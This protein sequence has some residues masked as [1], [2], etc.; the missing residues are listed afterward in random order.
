MKNSECRI[1]RR[2]FLKSCGL[3]AIGLT[4]GPC[5]GSKVA[6]PKARQQGMSTL[7]KPT[8]KPDEPL[9][10][11]SGKTDPS[12]VNCPDCKEWMPEIAVTLDS[13]LGHEDLII[14]VIRG[15][16]RKTGLGF[17]DGEWQG[18]MRMDFKH[19]EVLGHGDYIRIPHCRG[20]RFVRL[21]VPG[22]G[23]SKDIVDF[24]L[25]P[26]INSQS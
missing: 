8:E 15:Y 5:P 16:D 20:L 24:A 14:D 13:Y 22:I 1:G 18:S 4:I 26:I 10:H 23:V 2:D 21:S 3:A 25:K 9:V 17:H 11:W 19:S 12:N 7:T 6:L